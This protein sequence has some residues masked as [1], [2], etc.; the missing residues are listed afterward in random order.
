MLEIIQAKIQYGGKLALSG[1]SGHRL[2]Q[3]V[4]EPLAAEQAG[5]LILLT[6]LADPLFNLALVHAGHSNHDLGTGFTVI[7]AGREGKGGIKLTAIGMDAL[8]LQLLGLVFVLGATAQQFLQLVVVRG[9]DHVHDRHT[10]QIIGILIAKHFHVVVIG[11][12]MHAIEYV[13]DGITAL[14]HEHGKPLFRIMTHNLRM[15]QF[16]AQAQE[17]DHAVHHQGNQ[18]PIVC[19]RHGT[20]ALVHAVLDGGSG[21]LIG[22][23]HHRNGLAQALEMG[24]GALEGAITKARAAQHQFPGAAL[25]GPQQVFVAQ[26]QLCPGCPA[27]ITQHVHELLCLILGVMGDQQAQIVQGITH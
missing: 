15:L 1:G 10:R 17:L 25:Q 16:L 24:H 19:R 22:K 26:C 5:D 8:A 4:H 6:D 20:G 23:Q 3:L 7:G 12:D 13:G 11:M 18:F 27:C 9:R 2:V 14:I 21:I